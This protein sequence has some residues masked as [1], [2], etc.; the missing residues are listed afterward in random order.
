MFELCLNLD[1]LYESGPCLVG[2]KLR[3]TYS[4]TSINS[5]LQGEGGI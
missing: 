1:G 3:A 4:D 2:F 5:K